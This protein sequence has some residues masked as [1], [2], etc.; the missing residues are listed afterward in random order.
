MCACFGVG[1]AVALTLL[2]FF[3]F[4]LFFSICLCFRDSGAGFSGDAAAAAAAGDEDGAVATAA[5]AG[6][7]AAPAPDDPS[8][9]VLEDVEEMDAP[10]ILALGEGFRPSAEDQSKLDEIDASVK[11]ATVAVGVGLEERDRIVSLFFFFLFFFFWLT[12]FFFARILRPSFSFACPHS[13]LNHFRASDSSLPSSYR[14]RFVHPPVKKLRKKKRVAPAADATATASASA[15]SVAAQ[16][17]GAAAAVAAIAANEDEVSQKRASKLPETSLIA[18]RKKK[19]KK[20][21]KKWLTY[22]AVVSIVAVALVRTRRRLRPR[23]ICRHPTRP[24]SRASRSWCT[25]PLPLHPRPPRRWWPP[26]RPAR[27]TSRPTAPRSTC[28]RRRGWS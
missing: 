17:A 5:G 20:K 6:A 12:R 2:C 19:K 27:W 14:P 10:V 23:R 24:W 18:T 22:F 16:T 28:P 11:R 7:A 25:R 26:A 3:G 1:G 13:L 4:V 8:L 21:K 9:W 15:A